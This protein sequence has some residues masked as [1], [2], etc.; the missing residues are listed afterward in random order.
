MSQ[1]CISQCPIKQSSI[2]RLRIS[3]RDH[4]HHLPEILL[5]H[6]V[7]IWPWSIPTTPDLAQSFAKINLDAEDVEE[8]V[9]DPISLQ[10]AAWLVSRKST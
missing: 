7:C 1:G 10:F 8:T 9:P 5:S 2:A 4:I 6:E 3:F